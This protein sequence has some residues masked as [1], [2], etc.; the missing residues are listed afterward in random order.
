MGV[1]NTITSSQIA[2]R[3]KVGKVGDTP[4]YEVGL[5]GGLHLIM[6]AGSKVPLGAGPHRAVARHIAKKKH[7]EITFDELSKSDWL[8]PHLYEAM[9]PKYELI[10]DRLIRLA[11]E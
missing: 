11:S 7:P 2:Y 9:L 6:K 5:I 10:T 1:S 3:K 4:V 8:E